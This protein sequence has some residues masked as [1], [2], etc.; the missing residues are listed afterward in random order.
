VITT[1]EQPVDLIAD[2]FSRA[3]AELVRARRRQR[4][5]DS[6]GHRADVAE[7]RARIDLVL[8]LFL[9]LRTACPQRDG[10]SGTPSP[11]DADTPIS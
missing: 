6:R 2:D 1:Q 3:C 7:C 8:D 5:K 9:E 4:E 11:S 10:V